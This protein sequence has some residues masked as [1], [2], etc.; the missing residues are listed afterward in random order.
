MK[1]SISKK[2]MDACRQKLL[3]LKQRHVENLKTLSSELVAES[4]GDVGDQARAL[5]EETMALARREKISQELQEV[6]QAL[7]RIK[8]ET[9]GVCEETG[10]PIE[11]KRLLAVPWTRLSLEGAEIRE[12]EQNDQ[13]DYGA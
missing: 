10:A 3:E 5:Q 8:N 1:S 4:S 13:E 11:E 12:M 2:V 7:D 6:N 9:F